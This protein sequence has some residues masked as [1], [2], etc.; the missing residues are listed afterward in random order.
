MRY[1]FSPIVFLLLAQPAAADEEFRMPFPPAQSSLLKVSP[2]DWKARVKDFNDSAIFVNNPTRFESCQDIYYLPVTT[3]HYGNTSWGGICLT[4]T[5]KETVFVCNDQ[6][7][8]HFKVFKE[9]QLDPG[10]IA[11]TIFEN[12]W[13]G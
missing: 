12:C 6:M 1:L 4:A 10:W 3:S 13:G 8:G 2:I 11:V 5:S 9:F 7:N